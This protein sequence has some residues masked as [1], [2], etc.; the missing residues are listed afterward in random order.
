MEVNYF[1]STLR[2]KK[3][4]GKLLDPLCEEWN[5]TRNE[6]EVMLF[7]ANNPG[8]DRAV[9]IVTKRGIAKSHVSLSVGNLEKR[10]FLTRLLDEDDRRT[11]HLALSEEAKAIAQTARE[12]QVAFFSKVFYGLTPEE[13]EIWRKLY[14]KVCK[15]IEHLDDPEW[16]DA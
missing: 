11:I 7:L 16:F 6:L 3:K 9:D 10:G 15:N 12:T 13:R 1:D 14:A 8:Y 5:L 4:Y 2:A